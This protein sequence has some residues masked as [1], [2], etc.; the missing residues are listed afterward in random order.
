MRIYYGVFVRAPICLRSS[1]GF[2]DSSEYVAEFR[3]GLKTRGLENT[4]LHD[5]VVTCTSR[6]NYATR[7]Y[8]E[9]NRRIITETKIAR[10]FRFRLFMRLVVTFEIRSV[11]VSFVFLPKNSVGQPLPC[12]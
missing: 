12:Q 9:R 5:G 2:H 11:C 4:L 7:S 10:R 8:R 1:I 6:F 3:G